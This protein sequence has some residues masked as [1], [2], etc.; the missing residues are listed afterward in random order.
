MKTPTAEDTVWLQHPPHTPDNECHSGVSAANFK[1][2][3]N[4]VKK[5]GICCQAA[6]LS[7][8]F[9]EKDLSSTE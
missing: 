7:L 5:L 6:E 3:T 4:P 2:R 1:E 9:H 8:P